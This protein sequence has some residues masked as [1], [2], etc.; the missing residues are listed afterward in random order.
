MHGIV[1]TLCRSLSLIFILIHVE[2]RTLSASYP[3]SQYNYI[4]GSASNDGKTIYLSGLQENNA[5]PILLQTKNGGASYSTLT[6]GDMKIGSVATTGDGKTMVAGADDGVYLGVS[7]DKVSSKYLPKCAIQATGFSSYQVSM[8][9]NGKV[10]AA[11]CARA[12][13]LMVSTDSGKSWDK[14]PSG[15]WAS[16]QVSNSGDSIIAASSDSVYISKNSG[17]TWNKSPFTGAYNSA[18]VSGDGTVFYVNQYASRFGKDTGSM[19]KS[20]DYGQ[21][22]EPVAPCIGLEPISSFSGKNV[23]VKATN[24]SKGPWLMSTNAGQSFFQTGPKPDN[25]GCRSWHTIGF[26]NQGN[27]IYGTCDNSLYRSTNDGKSWQS[28]GPA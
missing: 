1:S 2:S 20:T 10:M 16:V 5:D 13:N 22:W 19:V 15:K 12:G 21:T 7:L 11:G 23:L 14:G 3:L 27:S 6:A 18:T 4:A 25:G 28:I 8:S 17:K 9:A 26:S 24:P